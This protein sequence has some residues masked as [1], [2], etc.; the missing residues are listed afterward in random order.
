MATFRIDPPA[1]TTGRVDRSEITRDPATIAARWPT[2]QVLAVTID[3]GVPVT[4]D[5]TGLRLVFRPSTDYGPQPPLGAVLIGSLGGIHHWAVVADSGVIPDPAPTA[6]HVI[7]IRAIG[8]QLSDD[9]AATAATAVALL[10]WHATAIF[11]S[12]CGQVTVPDIAGRSRRCPQ[13]HEEFPRTDPAVIVLVHDGAD[14][15]VLGRQPSWDP[16]R[17][18]VLAGFAEAGESLEGT[19]AREMGEEIGVAVSDIEY[20]GSQ[21]WPFP[22][23]LMI[24]FAARAPRGAP[25]H[26]RPGELDQARW[27]SRGELARLLPTGSGAAASTAGGLT[28]PSSL[29]IAYRMIEAFVRAG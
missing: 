15:A 10:R 14:R 27:F 19:V 23:S 12:R 5:A 4:E 6:D 7:P 22:R 1:L 25:L 3:G 8:P 2:A 21:P 20:L 16:G 24:A 26:P 13:G 11:C 9:D 17:F 29:S 28:L 18:S